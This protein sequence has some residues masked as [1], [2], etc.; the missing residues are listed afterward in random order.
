M[1]R[2]VSFSDDPNREGGNHE[3][4]IA[5]ISRELISITKELDIPVAPLSQLTM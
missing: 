4:E 5:S 1:E 3:Q 2:H